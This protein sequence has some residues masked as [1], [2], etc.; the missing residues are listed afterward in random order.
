MALI[1]FKSGKKVE[2][3]TD[4]VMMKSSRR[5]R[6]ERENKGLGSRQFLT[7]VAAISVAVAV[8]AVGFSAIS[9]NEA[10]T[11]RKEVSAQTNVVY[12]LKADVAQGN[13]FDSRNVEEL[14]VADGVVPTGAIVDIK[15]LDGQ[16]ANHNIPA[17]AILTTYDFVVADERAGDIAREIEDGYVGV[18]FV[19]SGNSAPAVLSVGD[20]V[21][22]VSYDKEFNTFATE[23]KVIAIDS[24]P[25]AKL[26]SEYS[27]V[28]LQLDE[29]DTVA[30]S[31]AGDPVRLVLLPREEEEMPEGAEEVTEG[32]E[33]AAGTEGAEDNGGEG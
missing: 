18:R 3:E 14:L 16:Q 24:D 12:R 27:S 26:V 4:D 33:T 2:E 17:G 31:H 20:L 25:A 22:V 8:G 9:F 13:Y 30:I 21:D 15:Q 28:T 6:A 32:G 11:L 19:V 7:S 10:S 23:I 1:N 29:D 5:R